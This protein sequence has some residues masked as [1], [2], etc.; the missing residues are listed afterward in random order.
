MGKIPARFSET[1]VCL[2]PFQHQGDE[3][4]LWACKCGWGQWWQLCSHGAWAR[5]VPMCEAVAAGA[6][7]NFTS[8]EPLNPLA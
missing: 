3:P 7:W 5:A 1:L 8:A 6:G 4:E 2:W